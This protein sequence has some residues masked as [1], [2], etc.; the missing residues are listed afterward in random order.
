MTII[1]ISEFFSF[2]INENNIGSGIIIKTRDGNN[3][4]VGIITE[5]YVVHI[6]GLLEPHLLQIRI[7]EL[8]SKP[9]ITLHPN[10]TI[11]DAIDIMQLNNIRRIPIV[12]KE[13]K[14]A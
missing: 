2:I 9:L 7:H 10:N 8:M 1:I 12:E 11:K 14:K 4:A 13:N 5:R 6:I 3:H